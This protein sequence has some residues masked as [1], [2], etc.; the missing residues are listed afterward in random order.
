MTAITKVRFSDRLAGLCA[1]KRPR[2]NKS[3]H[4]AGAIVEPVTFS[5]GKTYASAV[6]CVRKPADLR[7]DDLAQAHI[8]V[9]ASVQRRDR[10]LPGSLV[11]RCSAGS[12]LQ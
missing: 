2:W 11:C 1:S 7:Y 4:L 10:S 12:N 3:P 9:R 6:L 5:L 8:A